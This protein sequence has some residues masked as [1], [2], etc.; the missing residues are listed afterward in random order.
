MTLIDE[1]AIEKITAHSNMSPKHKSC[2]GSAGNTMIAP[3]QLGE[4]S[5]YSCK[6]GNDNNGEFFVSELTK[7]GLS[8]NLSS[9]L[10]V[11]KTGQCMVFVTP[12]AERTMNT[13]LE[14]QRHFRK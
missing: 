11:G 4:Q 12:D 13:H 3:A 6:V 7:T 1:A 10:P 8:T 2:G 5:F 14:L 9:G